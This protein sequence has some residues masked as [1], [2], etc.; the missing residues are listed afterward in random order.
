[1]TTQGQSVAVSK[2]VYITFSG[3]DEDWAVYKQRIETIAKEKGWKDVLTTYDENTA[4]DE[5]QKANTTALK[6]FSMS[7]MDHA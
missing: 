2:D 7:L 3:E 5:E 6:Y 1:M 4:T